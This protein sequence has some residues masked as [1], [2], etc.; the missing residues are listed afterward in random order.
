LS[1]GVWSNA[2]SQGTKG[3]SLRKSTAGGAGA[4]LGGH[5]SDRIEYFLAEVFSVTRLPTERKYFRHQHFAGLA[6]VL[7]SCCANVL[8][9]WPR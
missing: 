6:T 5:F 4:V 8:T 3:S 1:S 7:M 9:S 2:S